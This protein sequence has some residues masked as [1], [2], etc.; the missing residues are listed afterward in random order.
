MAGRSTPLS[1]GALAIKQLTIRTRDQVVII[2]NAKPAQNSFQIALH[3]EKLHL[4][5]D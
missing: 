4:K 3:V 1:N 5:E 2:P